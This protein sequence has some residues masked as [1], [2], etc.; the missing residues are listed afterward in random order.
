MC[1]K[2]SKTHL[3]PGGFAEYF[4]VPA[5]NLQVDCF[6]IPDSV[7]FEEATLIEPV[8]CGVRAIKECAIQQGDS[9][10]II[11]A[12]PAGVIN[13]ALARLSGAAQIIV[14]DVIP[15][16]LRAAQKFGV[17]V[18]INVQNENLLD[19]VTAVTESRGADVVV[20]TAPNVK[21]Y[22]SALEICRKGGTIC[23]FA[24]TSP[25]QTIPLSPHKLFFQ[26]IKI[27]SSYSTSHLETRTALELIRSGRI[28]AKALITHR[29]PLSRAAE[30]FQAVAKNKECLK[31]VIL[32]EK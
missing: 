27:V 18:T 31:V 20:V 9:V 5:D 3:E 28:D 29:F 25:E 30:A 23:V 8:A 4:R 26:E 15:Y 16:R 12:G 2:F 24:P 14:S 1:Q 7:S 13:S 17:D 32:N 19:K 6:Q 10:V 11:G 21:A 22:A